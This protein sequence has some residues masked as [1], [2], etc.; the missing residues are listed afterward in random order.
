M[1]QIIQIP[2][3]DAHILIWNTK[4]L[5]LR[6]TLVLFQMNCMALCVCR[7]ARVLG[8]HVK[9]GTVKL[10]WNS[11]EMFCY[12]LVKILFQKTGLDNHGDSRQESQNI[13]KKQKNTHCKIISFVNYLAC[14]LFQENS[15][16]QRGGTCLFSLL[17]ELKLPPQP[18][19]WP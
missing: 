10:N 15:W 13:F 3:T 18:L 5:H 19:Y 14:C 6:A 11:W 8:C 9:S 4:H 16:M 1:I 12:K 7:G 2:A 17:L